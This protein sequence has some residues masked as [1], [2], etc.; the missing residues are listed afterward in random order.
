MRGVART[1]PRVRPR[2]GSP[3]ASRT[4]RLLA[5]AVRWSNMPAT[6]APQACVRVAALA[7]AAADEA[8]CAAAFSDRF[9]TP[10]TQRASVRPPRWSRP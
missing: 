3:S 9:G 8:A 7:A 6:P 4:G 10:A 5:G 1:A 2:V